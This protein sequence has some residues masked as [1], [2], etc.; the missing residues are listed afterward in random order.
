MSYDRNALVTDRT[1]ADVETWKAFRDKGAANMTQD[2]V[3]RWNAGL[4]GAYSY[5]DLNRVGEA[6]GYARDILAE[7]GYI[8]P[9]AFTA[10][11]DWKIAEI[12]TETDIAF[13]LDCVKKVREAFSFSVYPET[14]PAPVYGGALDYIEANDI[15]RIIFDIDTLIEKMLAARFYSGDLFCGEV[16]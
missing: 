10:K 3:I 9:T 16:M 2:E 1:K 4:K 6:L 15:E 11:N 14:P 12:P 8:S 5:K 13:Y 7:T